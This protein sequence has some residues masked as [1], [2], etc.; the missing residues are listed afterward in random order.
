MGEIPANVVALYKDEALAHIASELELP[1][2][3]K[4]HVPTDIA[5]KKVGDIAL[6]EESVEVLIREFYPALVTEHAA[7]AVAAPISALP[8]LHPASR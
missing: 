4:G 8:N 5:L 3:R 2:F 6:L 7:D 1:G